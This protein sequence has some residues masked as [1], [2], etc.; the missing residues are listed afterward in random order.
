MPNSEGGSGS[1]L[2]SQNRTDNVNSL[3]SFKTREGQTISVSGSTALLPLTLSFKDAAGLLDELEPW[4]KRHNSQPS[5]C[6][7]R[8][9]MHWIR[10]SLSLFFH[11]HT[12]TYIFLHTRTHTHM[13]IYIHTYTHTHT[14]TL[15]IK[16]TARHTTN[17][18]S[19]IPQ[20]KKKGRCV[21]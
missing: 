4:C 18:K 5:T 8:F 20:N 6:T 9:R 17:G 3:P 7:G 11:S 21:T 15:I 2:G 19:L 13:C 12:H 1:V 10:D 16:R 14:H